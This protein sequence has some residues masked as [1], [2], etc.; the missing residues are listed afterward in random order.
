VERNLSEKDI[1]RVGRRQ[2]G[3][4]L[5]LGVAWCALAGCTSSGSPTTKNGLPVRVVA[6]GGL[7]FNVLSTKSGRQVS[8][9]DIGA[10]P[11]PGGTTSAVGSLAVGVDGRQVFWT[12]PGVSAGGQSTSPVLESAIDGHGSNRIVGH[13]YTA[14]PSPNGQYLLIQS[15]GGSAALG[16]VRLGDLK[17]I[18]QL[19]V[20]AEGIDFYSWLPDSTTVIAVRSLFGCRGPIG[21]SAA[22]PTIPANALAWEISSKAAQPKWTPMQS[23]GNRWLGVSILGPGPYPD[24]VD[25]VTSSFAGPQQTTLI[26]KLLVINPTGP[27]FVVQGEDVTNFDA[28]TVDHTG[29][30][31]LGTVGGRIASVSL[32]DPHPTFITEG[33][34]NRLAWW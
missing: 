25:A 17:Q 3:W 31:F 5:L 21:C 30:D 14:Q 8:G 26:T 29:Q 28:Y 19:P 6:S 12:D 9:I 18:T 27:R 33:P 2:V 1:R 16:V 10:V 15:I 23:G 4:G 11:D 7:D 20:I 24:T 13:G 22:T 32:T 34:Y